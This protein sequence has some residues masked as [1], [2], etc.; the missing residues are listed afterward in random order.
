MPTAKQIYNQASQ[1]PAE[2]RMS[3]V[4]QILDTL[5]KRDSLLDTQWAHEVE[6]RL[7]AYRRGEF[8]AIPLTEVIAQLHRRPAYW[9]D[10]VN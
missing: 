5:D 8:Q 2:E 4:D 10:R 1:L 7:A 6:S 9:Q 3:L